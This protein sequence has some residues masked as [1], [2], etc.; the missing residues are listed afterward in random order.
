VRK[1]V[2]RVNKRPQQES[3]SVIPKIT[4]FHHKERSWPEYLLRYSHI[5]A[6]RSAGLITTDIQSLPQQN[7]H[8]E[9][10]MLPEPL[11]RLLFF[12]KPDVIVSLDDGIR[13]VRAV[14]AIDVTEHV[15]ARD[16]WIQRFPNLVGCAQEG[17]PGAFIAPRDM[18]ARAKFAGKT[19]PFFFFAYDRVV[20]LHN[21]PIYIA[22]WPSSDSANLDTD[23]LFG[24]LPPH[25]SAGV[26]NVLHFLKLSLEASLHGR[27]FSGLVRERLIVDL[28]NEVRKIGYQKIPLISDFDRLKIN[29]PNG[30]PLTPTEF[31]AWLN[32][33]GHTLPN[34]LP[35]RIRKRNR[36]LIF[37]PTLKRNPAKDRANLLDRIKKRGGDPYTQQPLVFD[38]LFCRTGPT[39]AERD[40]NFVIDLTLLKFAD[41]A[42]YISEAWK[43]SPLQYT[44]FSE[45]E[46]QIPR[47]T[48]HLSSGISQVVK[49]FVR[50]YSYVADIIIF[51]DGILYF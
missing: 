12:A 39:P 42:S 49:N 33:R 20:E 46:S 9:F 32:A 14:F 10:G 29:L 8:L 35:D 27:D 5:G 17:I 2:K 26:V 44:D 25:D 4:I 18:G 38:Y 41:F 22:E 19:D 11:R 45:V 24:D 37:S 50:L 6:L 7:A 15:A 31:E 23:D 3:K 47:Y 36:S 16:H 13:P 28:R 48:L 40:T 30:R 43:A 1:R 51:E 34:H 21:S